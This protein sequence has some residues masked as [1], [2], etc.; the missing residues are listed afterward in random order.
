[1]VN[2][3]LQKR[4]VYG[5]EETKHFADETA[6]FFRPGDTTLLYGNL[7]SGKTCLTN[8]YVQSLGFS[9]GATSPSFSIIN[10]YDGKTLINHIDFYRIQDQNELYNLGL[11]DI[12]NSENINFIEWP[13][14]IEKR[15]YWE[16]YRIYID[17]IE[18]NLAQRSISLIKYS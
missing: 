16:H 5:I 13:Q 6:E 2:K 9:A 11:D 4:N 10:Q 15:I 17:F 12:F 7:G 18:N 3:T 1:M 8:F 14:I